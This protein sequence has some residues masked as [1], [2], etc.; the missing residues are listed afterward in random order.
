[1]TKKYIPLWLKKTVRLFL[2]LPLLFCFF[3]ALVINIALYFLYKKFKG[4]QLSRPR[5]LFGVT[6]II[7]LAYI[8]RSLKSK[9]YISH[10]V[11]LSESSIYRKEDFDIILAPGKN[12]PKVL[13]FMIGCTQ[14]YCFFIR[15]IWNYD[16]FHYYYDGGLL[17]QTLVSKAELFILKLC[18]KR[19][20]LFPYGSDA[21]VYDMIPNPLWRQALMLEYSQYG[22]ISNQVQKRI[23]RMTYYADVVIACLVHF[24]NLPRWDILPLTCYP[25]D[26]E[27]LQPVFL[28]PNKTSQIKVAHASNHRGV[29]GTVFLIDAVERLKQ[30]GFDIELDIIEKISNEEALKRI[31]ACDIYVDQLL[32]GYAQAAL[33]AMAFGKVV[34]SALE[35]PEYQ[36]FR[37]FSYLNECP[38]ISASPETIYRVLK[39]LILKPED[40]TGLGKASRE[41]VEHRHSYEACARMF[42]AI[43]QKIWFGDEKI[44]LINFYNPVLEKEL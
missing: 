8:S 26:T 43:Y 37:R 15:A 33:E 42:T 24:V 31:S 27:K 10:T 44:D 36:L 23:R 19:I 22:N 4:N 25:V 3:S 9:G 28:Y 39:A 7:S 32:F 2:D 17:S 12:Y 5:L 30:D 21:F 29:K 1:M 11:V 16:I 40:W 41:F 34:I 35:G 38:I 6:P 14:V 13:R 18:R 20:V